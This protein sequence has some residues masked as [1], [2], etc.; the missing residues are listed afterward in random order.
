[1]EEFECATEQRENV[2][3]QLEAA[4]VALADDPMVSEEIKQEL[5]GRNFLL[6]YSCFSFDPGERSVDL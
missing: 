5:L 2:L 1:M 6:R 3:R 4:L